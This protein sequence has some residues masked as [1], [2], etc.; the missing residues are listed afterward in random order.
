MSFH[1]LLSLI[2]SHFLPSL[3]LLSYCQAELLL[4]KEK[5]LQSQSDFHHLK[6]VSQSVS[7]YSYCFFNIQNLFAFIKLSHFFFSSAYHSFLLLLPLTHTCGG[8]FFNTV[9]IHPPFPFF[10]LS[11]LGRF[12]SVPLILSL[13]FFLF[14]SLPPFQ[15]PSRSVHLSL[16]LSLPPF[17]SLSI[18]LSIYIFLSFSLSFSVTLSLLLSL[19]LSHS[20]H[21]HIFVSSLSLSLS[22][23]PHI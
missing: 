4:A 12:L 20:L 6:N 18:S 22:I 23:F 14:A 21:T 1:F 15:S 16:S 8:A 7:T 5:V 19:L 11:L 10:S 13:P 2:S 3:L 9:S 17:L